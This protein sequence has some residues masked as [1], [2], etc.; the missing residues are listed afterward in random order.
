MT[1]HIPNI[2]SSVETT[3]QSNI[4]VICHECDALQNI[5]KLNLSNVA[6]CICC[7]S[8]LFKH[9]KNAIERPLALIIASMMLFIVANLYP[10]MTLT[11][12]GIEQK[13][14]LTGSGLIFLEQGSPGLAAA[15]WIPSVFIP[16]CI[17][18]GLFY[19]LLSIY[20][21]LNWP[22]RKPI[23][24]WV[25]RLLPWGMMDVF[26]LGI[27]VAL[28]KLAM[29]ADILLGTGLFAFI[30]LIFVYAA[31]C[32]SLEPRALWERLDKQHKMQK[33]EQTLP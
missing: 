2:P 22:F 7:G 30:A 28:V 14:T 5:S 26:L 11:I 24:V 21:S 6:S 16:G 3:E 31:A 23:L 12:R 9:H 17:I 29:L 20:Y 27:L 13:T 25:S 19:I 8:V 4:L 33:T 10:L 18:F 15:V 1:L 32:S